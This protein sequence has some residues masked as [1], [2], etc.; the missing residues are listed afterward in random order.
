MTRF[1]N[2]R[3]RPK[4]D[5]PSIDLGTPEL[6]QKKANEETNESLDICLRRGLIEQSQHWCGIHLRWL[7]TIRYGAPGVSAIQLFDM[8]QD[9]TGVVDEQWRKDRESEYIDAVCLLAKHHA[10]KPIV[11]ICIYNE[12]PGFLIHPQKIRRN[13]ADRKYSELE[14]F[15]MGLDLLYNYWKK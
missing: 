2:K 1:T 12:I 3:G 6:I 4:S 7:H 11:N 5:K 15:R 13:I 10:L 14:R 8:S 9:T